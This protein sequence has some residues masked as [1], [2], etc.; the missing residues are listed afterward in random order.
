MKK[1]YEEA[2]EI[3]RRHRQIVGK[4][5]KITFFLGNHEEWGRKFVDKYP[6]LEGL[7]EP[8]IMLPLEELGMEVIEPRHL[9]KIGKIHFIHGDIHRG[10]FVSA[11]HAKKI[12]ETYNRNVVYG[13]HHTQQSYTK[14][15]P[16]GIQ[17][18]HTAFCVPCLANTN[19]EWAGD[20]PNSWL[21]GFGVFYVSPTNF[22]LQTVVAVHNSF[23]APNGKEYR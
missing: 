15:S 20:R 3:L 4:D 21:N 12:V 1:D 17:D 18:T 2:G 14:I 16:A 22:H 13:H 8:E 10:N 19:P 6:T 23:I 9:K 11:A 5:C 7:I